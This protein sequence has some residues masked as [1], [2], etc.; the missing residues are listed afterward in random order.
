M[1]FSLASLVLKKKLTALNDQ[2][3][4][5]FNVHVSDFDQTMMSYVFDVIGSFD[6]FNITFIVLVAGFSKAFALK[7]LIVSHLQAWLFDD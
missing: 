5:C 7:L 4:I 3:S 6:R 1:L 2:G